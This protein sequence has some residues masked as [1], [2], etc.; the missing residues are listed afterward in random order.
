MNNSCSNNPFLC[1]LE[2]VTETTVNE[3]KDNTEPLIHPIYKCHQL[4]N[5]I[6]SSFDQM[7]SALSKDSSWVPKI[8]MK[9]STPFIISQTINL[10]ITNKN[11]TDIVHFMTPPSIQL[12]TICKTLLCYPKDCTFCF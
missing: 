2:K 8:V 11:E 9:I 5:T 10:P 4:T 6:S 1:G 12:S 7:H 3:L